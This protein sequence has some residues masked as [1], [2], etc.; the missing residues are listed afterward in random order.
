MPLYKAD[1]NDSTKQ[2][3][4]VQ[5]SNR[6]DKAVNPAHCSATKTPSYV[7]INTFYINKMK[8]LIFILN[9]N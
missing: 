1:P 9:E 6:F 2:T 4:D 7:L 8:R 3:P 5:G